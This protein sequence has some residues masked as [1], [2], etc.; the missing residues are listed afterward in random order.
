MKAKIRDKLKDKSM[1]IEHKKFTVEKQNGVIKVKC[2]K[3]FSISYLTVF[4]M[5]DSEQE[6]SQGKSH[7]IL[8]DL[9]EIIDIEDKAQDRLLEDFVNRNI[10]RCAVLTSNNLKNWYN[11][12][13]IQLTET[14]IPIRFFHTEKAALNW[15]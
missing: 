11:N 2:K 6:L 12:L 15:M 3:G 13:K 7:P 10:T 8:I 5:L 9:S 14:K 1:P 4:K